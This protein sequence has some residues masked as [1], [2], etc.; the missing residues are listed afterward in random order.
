[1]WQGPARW[2]LYRCMGWQKCITEQHPDKYIICLAPH[3]SNHDFLLGTLYRLAEGWRVNFLMK[4][5][6][7]F[8]PLGWI[9]KRMGGIP[10]HRSTRTNLTQQLVQAAQER[11]WFHLC[12]TPEGTRSRTNHWRHGFYHIAN[13]AGMPILLYALDYSKKNIQCTKTI[14]PTGDLKADMGIINDYFRNCVG[15]HPEKFA[16]DESLDDKPVETKS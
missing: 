6:W 12:V 9:F 5:E 10:V 15:K 7:F 11:E 1:M 14:I 4:K 13:Q 3:T 8:F 2:L 16:L